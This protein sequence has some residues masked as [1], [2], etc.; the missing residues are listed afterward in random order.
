M[1]SLQILLAIL[2]LELCQDYFHIILMLLIALCEDFLYRHND[3][4]CNDARE[5]STSSRNLATMCEDFLFHPK[6]TCRNL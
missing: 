2:C 6:V 1:A 5:L 4:P 3:A